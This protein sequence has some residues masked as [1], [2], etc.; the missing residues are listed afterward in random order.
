M[1]F[2]RSAILASKANC[3]TSLVL[4]VILFAYN[5]IQ[6]H[7]WTRRSDWIDLIEMP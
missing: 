5:F 1:I 7:W 2:A 4:L 3:Q 6:K